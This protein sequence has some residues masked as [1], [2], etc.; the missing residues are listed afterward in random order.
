MAEE[1]SAA[2]REELASLRSEKA[3]KEKAENRDTHWVHLAN[4]KVITQRG[5]GG[6]HYK[7]IPVIGS[8]E[9]PEDYEE[10]SSDE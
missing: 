6:T 3:A 2:E 10:D 1:M 8:Y 4:G 5:S 7:G 9:I